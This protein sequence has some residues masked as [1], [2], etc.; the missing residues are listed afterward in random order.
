MTGRMTLREATHLP[1]TISVEEAGRLLG[2]GRSAAYEAARR[3]DIPVLRFG[4]GR[5]SRLYVKTASLL[6]MLGFD[7]A[8]GGAGP[9]RSPNAKWRATSPGDPPPETTPTLARRKDHG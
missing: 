2:I 4:S 9:P 3:G 6:E 1:P 5:G 7:L 8:M